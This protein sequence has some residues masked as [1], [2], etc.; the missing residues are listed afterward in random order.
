MRI[1]TVLI[2]GGLALSAGAWLLFDQLIFFWATFL[3]SLLKGSILV[4]V[5]SMIRR[6]F[7]VELPK[8]VLFFLIRIGA[9]A[10]IQRKVRRAVALSRLWMGNV[11]LFVIS[12]T[13]TLLGG[14]SS[15]VVALVATLAIGVVAFALTGTYLVWLIGPARFVEPLLWLSR[16]LMRWV[17]N[18]L[19]KLVANTGL[20]RLG[21]WLMHLIPIAFRIRVKYFWAN[22]IR[23]RKRLV[24][25]I[26]GKEKKEEA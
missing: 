22:A 13:K 16:P 19:F 4:W 5:S 24:R 6:W 3:G 25:K 10:R 9:P 12:K 23:T 8:L 20:I 11:K 14:D 15:F 26:E 18:F 21:K 2:I 17:Q 1:I 7:L